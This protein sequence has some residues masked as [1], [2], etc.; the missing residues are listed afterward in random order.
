MSRTE[1]GEKAHYCLIGG[2]QEYDPSQR[3]IFEELF[4]LKHRENLDSLLRGAFY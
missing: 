4:F 2:L 1:F 3:N